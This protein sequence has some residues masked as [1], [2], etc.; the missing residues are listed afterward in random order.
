MS[1]ASFKNAS[2]ATDSKRRAWLL[3][4]SLLESVPPNVASHPLSQPGE[5]QGSRIQVV[6]PCGSEHQHNSLVV[7]GTPIFGN[8]HI[9]KLDHL[10]DRGEISKKSLKIHHPECQGFFIP[11]GTRPP[12]QPRPW[13]SGFSLDPG[14]NP[15]KRWIVHNL[16]WDA[17]DG[18]ERLGHN[19]D[20]DQTEQLLF[21]GLEIWGF[22]NGIWGRLGGRLRMTDMGLFL[23]IQKCHTVDASEIRR[24]PVDMVNIP[25]FTRF[26]TSQV[27]QDFFHQ[28]Y[29]Q[30]LNIGANYYNHDGS[31]GRLYAYVPTVTIQINHSCW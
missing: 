1:R 8:I 16:I 21:H 6:D 30:I 10:Q 25:L 26:Y 24:S 5:F 14:P 12:I 3:W 4:G 13:K 17:T 11:P 22:L 2:L 7:E 20:L 15:W 9:V 29:E 31:M 18:D 27:V 28:Q 23:E 19:P